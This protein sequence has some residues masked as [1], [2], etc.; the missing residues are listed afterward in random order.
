MAVDV[1]PIEAASIIES[2]LK[3][4][5]RP[6]D[7]DDFTSVSCTD[8]SVEAVRLR[9]IAIPNEHPPE[10]SGEYCNSRGLAILREW[11]TGLREQVA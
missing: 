11:A 4:G 9:C 8:P 3:G 6:Y 2:F 5:G 1:N 10:N 7:W